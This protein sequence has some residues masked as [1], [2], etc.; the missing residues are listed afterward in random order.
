MKNRRTFLKL[1][2][3]SAVAAAVPATPRRSRA[4]DK[5]R[6]TTATTV[7][8]PSAPPSVEAEVRKQK[9]STED[10]LKVIRDYRLRNGD[11]LAFAFVPMR[12]RRHSASKPKAS[13]S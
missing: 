8:Q 11:D 1:L 6:R 4:A 5:T 2:A 3:A 10:L 12:P 7:P 9:K 13:A